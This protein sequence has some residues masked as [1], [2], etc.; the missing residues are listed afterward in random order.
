[1]ATQR[2]INWNSILMTCIGTLLLLLLGWVKKDLEDMK[3][4]LDGLAT[5]STRNTAEIEF[6][7]GVISELKEEN[8]AFRSVIAD[9]PNKYYLKEEE[10]E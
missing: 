4:T 10:I 2:E 5:A 9:F 7:R 8:K 6:N 3:V 1:M